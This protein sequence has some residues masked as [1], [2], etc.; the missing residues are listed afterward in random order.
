MEQLAQH[1][2]EEMFDAISYGACV[3]G[4]DCRIVHANKALIQLIGVPEQDLVGHRLCDVIPELNEVCKVCHQP[5]EWDDEYLR[6]LGEVVELQRGPAELIWTIGDSPARIADHG[7]SRWVTVIRDVTF[8]RRREEGL[9][10]SEKLHVFGEMAGGVLHDFGNLV[11]AILHRSEISLTA[12]LPEPARS[13]VKTIRDVAMD[14]AAV[15]H[16][17]QDFSRVSRE[18]GDKQ[19]DL[20]DVV[21]SALDFSRYK[22]GH[23][24]GKAGRR[25]SLVKDV[26]PV[27]AVRGTPSELREVF[28]NLILNAVDAI[29][30]GGT[31]TIR[32]T[33]SKTEAIV[34]VS[35]T[36]IG[37]P[38]SLQTRI[39]DPFFTTKGDHG[40]GLGLSV[41]RSLVERLGGAI[42]MQSELGI[43]TTFTVRLPIATS[44]NEPGDHLREDDSFS[45]IGVRG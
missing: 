9:L 19:A 14:A 5:R 22:W 32:T 39:F 24:L 4:A 33:A 34:T 44:P 17:L 23:E 38:P 31:I 7:V 35:D 15:V 30:T 10:H 6:H 1:D 21:N 25:I 36:G 12:D 20:A 41:S 28:I 26:R 3:R 40:S 45:H 13:S 42:T 8:Q 27:P 37:V 11:A 2:W 29:A 43:G 18:H 16:R